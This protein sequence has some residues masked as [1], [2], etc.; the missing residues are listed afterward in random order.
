MLLAWTNRLANRGICAFTDTYSAFSLN[1]IAHMLKTSIDKQK[2]K[3]LL[4]EGIHPSAIDI[5]RAAGYTQIDIS[6][7]APDHQNGPA[8][9]ICAKR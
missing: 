2:I 3:F 1:S 7:D 6:F 4:L 5:L 8:L 9:A